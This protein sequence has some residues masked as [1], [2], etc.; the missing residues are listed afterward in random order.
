MTNATS[1]PDLAVQEG[2]VLHR[3]H[4]CAPLSVD[5]LPA[6]VDRDRP[7]A[8]LLV[9]PLGPAQAIRVPD[10]PTHIRDRRQAGLRQLVVEEQGTALLDQLDD[11][12]ESSR[13]G[14]GWGSRGRG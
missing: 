11:S 6:A 13:R 1:G 8:R 5:L 12:V 7:Q 4:V 9:D 2:Q 14:P 10:A 3:L